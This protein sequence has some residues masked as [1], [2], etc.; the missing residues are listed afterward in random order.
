MST[1]LKKKR[2]TNWT[3]DHAT[4]SSDTS[5]GTV[6]VA[7]RIADRFPNR[8][9]TVRELCATYGM[10]RGTAYRWR[11]AFCAARGVN[12]ACLKTP[13]TRAPRPQEAFQTNQVATESAPI[14]W[15]RPVTSEYMPSKAARPEAATTKRSSTTKLITTK[16]E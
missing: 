6:E 8:I 14:T 11:N 7:V 12:P 3:E 15:Q 10:H 4:Q 13:R 9:P 2:R 1:D 16:D 5:N